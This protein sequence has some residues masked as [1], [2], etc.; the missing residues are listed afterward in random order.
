MREA[1]GSAPTGN[2]PAGM[3]VPESLVMPGCSRSTLRSSET[4]LHYEI[5]VYVPDIEPPVGGFPV[6]YVLDG[7]SDFITVAE[8]VRRV[9]RRPKATGIDPAIV[10]G[11]G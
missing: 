8:T 2:D 6:V 9:S 7:N 4:G 3:S 10:V 1:P 11:I 5:F